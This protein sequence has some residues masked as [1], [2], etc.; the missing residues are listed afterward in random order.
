MEKYGKIKT[1]LGRGGSGKCWVCEPPDKSTKY[2]VKD[3]FKIEKN[4]KKIL[5]EYTIGTLLN[6]SNIIKTIGLVFEKK[7]IYEILEL[8]REDL[9]HLL[10]SQKIS[11]EYKHQLFYE[12]LK[13]V[14][15]LHNLG[16]CHR[17]LKP[18]NCLIDFSGHLKI[19]DF[20]CAKV[21]RDCYSKK[22]YLCSERCG[23]IPY[24]PPEELTE[25][26]NYDGLPVDI[27]S[28][29]IILVIL[30]TSLFP[31]KEATPR[32]QIYKKYLTIRQISNT[33]LFI[34]NVLEPEPKSRW[35]IEKFIEEFK[36]KV[37][38]NINESG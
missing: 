28:T 24:M 26:G 12:L 9:H 37:R 2:A 32:D 13:G 22:V 30:L 1:L 38:L 10:I 7:H 4:K 34:R 3:F 33:P 20:G 6:H 27:W 11:L 16:I 15:Y 36:D 19:T 21:T 5:N 29:G 18:E 8:C 25:K 23:S 35:K 14:E 17:D 31:W